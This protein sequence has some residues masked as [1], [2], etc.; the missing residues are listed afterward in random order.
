MRQLGIPT[1]VDRLRA[2]GDPRRPW[3]RCST[4]RFRHRASGFRPGRGAHDALRQAREYV[5]DGYE[6]VVDLDLEKFFDRV[7]HDILMSR[8]ARLHRRARRLLRIIRRF[9]QAGMMTRTVCVQ[10]TA[11]GHAPAA[12]RCR[13]CCP[14]CCWTTWIRSWNARDDTASAVTPTIA[15]SMCGPQAAWAQRVMASVTSFLAG[16]APAEGQPDEE[17]R[18]SGRGTSVPRP[19]AG[20]G[21][22]LAWY[23]AQKSWPAPRTACGR[24]TRRNR[25]D[26]PLERM[27]EQANRFT[28]GWVT[29]AIATPSARARCATADGWLRRKLRCVELRKRCKLVRTMVRFLI[30]NGVTRGNALETGLV[31]KGMKV[32]PGPTAS[33]PSRPCPSR[34]SIGARVDPAGQPSCHT[35]PCRKPPWYAIRTPGGVRGALREGRPYSISLLQRRQVVDTGLRRHDEGG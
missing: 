21:R 11:R 27:I 33:R 6:I 7:N 35:E 2:A 23:R 12:A 31:G 16:Q 28:V 9:L 5:A 4:R 22:A 30:G 13:H 20:Q 17:R 26:C 25:G 8:L 10:R 1:V 18:R 14:I 29:Y 19:P 3:N 34:G 15:I 32:A 24:I